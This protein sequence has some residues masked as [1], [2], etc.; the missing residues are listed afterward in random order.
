MA[1]AELAHVTRGGRIESIH[2]G[3]LV[4][5]GDE[6]EFVLGNADAVIFPRSAVKPIQ[7]AAMIIAGLDLPDRLVALASASHSGDVFHRQGAT[8]ILTSVGLDPTAL[9]CPPDVPYGGRERV[10]WTR[11]GHGKEAI[12]HNCSGKHA[13]M[14]ATSA[15]NGWPIDSYRDPAHP[16]QRQIATLVEQ[17]AGESIA[18]TTVDGCGA[19]LFA[20]SIGGLA[21]SISAL[22]TSADSRIQRVV[23][24]MRAYPEMVAGTDRTTTLLMQS[25]D[26][27]IV[28]EGAEGV[29]IAGLADGRAVAVKVEDGSMRALPVITAS[30]LRRWGRG[31]AR[32][33]EICAAPVLGGGIPV[34]EIRA[35]L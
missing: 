28:K 7:A 26:G 2:R 14:I 8:E 21:R 12:A 19:P 17:L 33:D 4:I 31:S 15:I 24:A 25:V 3:H 20:M 13:A 16:L 35:L 27:L 32:V 18:G 9:Q 29:Q 23:A 5:T 6:N 30:V 1:S 22:I 11:A 34:G 10:E